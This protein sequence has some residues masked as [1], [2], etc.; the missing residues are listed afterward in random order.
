[1][2]GEIDDRGQRRKRK[3]ECKWINGVTSRDMDDG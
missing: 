1:M 3:V 2:G